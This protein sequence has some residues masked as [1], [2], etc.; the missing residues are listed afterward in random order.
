MPKLFLAPC[1]L[2]TATLAFSEGEKIPGLYMFSEAKKEQGTRQDAEGAPPAPRANK[3]IE[4]LSSLSRE[5]DKSE[6]QIKRELSQALSDGLPLV[7]AFCD[8]TI[9]IEY[10]RLAFLFMTD[11]P[12]A[13]EDLRE[14]SQKVYRLGAD[15][16]VGVPADCA[17]EVRGLSF[18]VL[19]VFLGSNWAEETPK[20]GPAKE[21]NA[22]PV[23][24]FDE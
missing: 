20:P 13:A 2:F 14:V 16:L 18:S 19:R 1:L 22:R 3:L 21:K 7:D 5:T 11:S 6:P 24:S 17:K 23:S 10:Y 4:S 12:G 15:G 8:R 9:A